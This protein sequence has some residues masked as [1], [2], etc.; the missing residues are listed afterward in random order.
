MAGLMKIVKALEESGLIIQGICETIKN[1]TNQQ[2][3][4]LFPM[5]LRTLTASILGNALTGKGV[6]RTGEGVIIASQNF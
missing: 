4:G 1:E 6:I 3:G 2:K 5:L